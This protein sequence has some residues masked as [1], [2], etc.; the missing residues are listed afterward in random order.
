ME[1]GLE[2]LEYS[3]IQHLSNPVC[4]GFT[5]FCCFCLHRV[6]DVYDYR[7]GFVR[8]PACFLSVELLNIFQLCQECVLKLS[9]KV[10]SWFMSVQYIPQFY[11]KLKTDAIYVLKNY[12]AQKNWHVAKCMSTASV[13]NIF[14]WK[15]KA[16][17]LQASSGPE[18]SRK[19]RF[20]DLMTTAQD[21]GKV[22]SLTH[23]PPLPPENTSGTHFC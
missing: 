7:E 12:P 4:I 17:P 13:W 5:E 9:L 20:P 3:I 18:C 1:V 23:R 6:C 22:V 10:K 11:V 2:N 8:L 19:L 21:G 14:F 16:V 15:G